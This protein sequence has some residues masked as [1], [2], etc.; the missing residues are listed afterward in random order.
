MSHDE[1][2]LS[3]AQVLEIVPSDDSWVN[4]GFAALVRSIKAPA[5]DSKKKF[6]TCL[7]G[8]VTGAAS[9]TMTVFFAPKFRVGDIIEFSGSGIKRTEY[10]GQ[11]KV[12]IG[13]KTEVH[14]RQRGQ[15]PAA[16]SPPAEEQRREQ[17][18][19]RQESAPSSKATLP[20]NGDHVL[21]VITGETA[22]AAVV[23]A[24]ELLA[25]DVSGD[26]LRDYLA[27]PV[28]WSRVH[29]TASDILRVSVLLQKG[30][31][32]PSVKERAAPPA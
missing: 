22:V 30:K 17:E 4:E 11:A 28:W 16:S 13:Q 25:R 14:I 32:A 24:H 15:T 26:E 20:A 8:D 3:V 10:N 18:P 12:T 2:P 27:D 1:Q 31:L 9:I 19:P 23:A 7:L 6:W 5:P 21:A 29:V